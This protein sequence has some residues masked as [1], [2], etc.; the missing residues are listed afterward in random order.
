M[1]R[2]YSLEE[3][4]E[5]DD[6][7]HT[8]YRLGKVFA[9]HSPCGHRYRVKKGGRKEQYILSSPPTPPP[10][11]PLACDLV[12]VDEDV[13]INNGRN[14]TPPPS[15]PP[16]PPERPIKKKRLD[17]LTCSV[18]FKLRTNVDVHIPLEVIDDIGKRDGKEGVVKDRSFVVDKDR[19]YKWLYRHDYY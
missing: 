8:K 4:M 13:I 3:L 11:P 19:F 15:T 10:E 5:L 9:E 17:D 6:A 12:A 16:P 14:V 18:C 7:I 2:P 1:D